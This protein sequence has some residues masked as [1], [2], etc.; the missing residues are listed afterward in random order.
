MVRLFKS[1]TAKLWALI[2]L[3]IVLSAL[4]IGLARLFTPMVADYRGEVEQFAARLLGQPVTVGQFSGEWRGLGPELVLTNTT[5]LDPNSHQP[6][7]TLP[8][9]RIQLALADSL[10]NWAITTREI[11]IIKPKL[12]VTRHHDGSFSSAGLDA[13]LE[14]GDDGANFF[15][16]PS[17]LSIEQGELLWIN[18]RVG[19]EPLHLTDVDLS[20]HN[21]EKRHQLN[22]S[23]TLPNAGKLRLA[24]DM[25][26][27]LE[28]PGSWSGQIYLKGDAI[29]LGAILHKRLPLAYETDRGRADFQVWSKIQTGQLTEMTGS[30][31]WRDLQLQ[32]QLTESGTSVSFQIDKL[33][34]DFSWQRQQ[35]GWRLDVNGLEFQTPDSNWPEGSLALALKQP[36]PETTELQMAS[37]FLRLQDLHRLLPLLPLELEGIQKPIDALAPTGDIQNL[38]LWLQQKGD[39]LH[40]RGEA[41]VSALH[42]QPWGEAP[43]ISN[44]SGK[45]HAN[46][47]SGQFELDTQDLSLNF[48]ELFRDPLVLEQLNGILSWQKQDNGDWQISSD[49]LIANNADVKTRTRFGFT[50]PADPAQ[51]P[52]LDLQTDFKDG[53][54]RQAPKYYPV[55]IMLD[56]LV[57]WLDNSII[58]GDVRQGSCLFRGRLADFPFDQNQGRFEVFF[59]VENATLEYMRGWPRLEGLNSNV[60][61]LNSRFDAWADGGHI[62][63]SHIE[64]ADAKIENLFPATALK[65]DGQVLGPFSDTL[66]L[67]RETPLAE[68]FADLTQGLK[69]S[70]KS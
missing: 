63:N 28:Q 14:G 65:I 18:E 33:A 49:E 40:W 48:T 9:V 23:V 39:D 13:D 36:A 59:R 32:R 4:V 55:G 47:L 31:N 29:N 37:S 12:R 30:G 67:L 24:T 10:R 41:D 6:N 5:L 70:G 54:G 64:K 17:R 46:Q 53:D 68:Q 58:S 21:S 52:F 60:R 38:T 45:L 43:G 57:K 26:G 15:L 34:G 7:L 11:R 19:H 56:D 50:L 35:Q 42:T 51:S 16:L 61:F 25:R 2:L 66:R 1:V 8:E 27:P 20:F 62:Y 3:L 22:G 44:L 69:P